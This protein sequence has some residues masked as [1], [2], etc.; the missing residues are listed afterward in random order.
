MNRFQ[1]QDAEDRG[2][3]GLSVTLVFSAA[4]LLPKYSIHK[5]T[6]KRKSKTCNG[7]M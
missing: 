7:H 4:I 3:F 2:V 5:Y 6:I 1:S